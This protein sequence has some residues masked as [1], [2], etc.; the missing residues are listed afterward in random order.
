MCLAKMKTVSEGLQ[1][2]TSQFNSGSLSASFMLP[3]APMPFA[4]G[5]APQGHIPGYGPALG[6]Q[7]HGYGTQAQAH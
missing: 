7:V 1:N 3:V 4:S 6:E 5:Y 2:T